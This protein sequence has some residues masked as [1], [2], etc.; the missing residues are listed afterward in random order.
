[1]KGVALVTGSSTGIGFETSIALARNGIY[2]F[3]TMRD[4]QKRD[5]IER[6]AD[7]ESLPLRVIEMDVNDEDSVERT[8]MK[9]IDKEKRID[10]LVNNAG[11]GL[12]GALEDI[13][14]EINSHIPGVLTTMELFIEVLPNVNAV[15]KKEMNGLTNVK[16]QK[17]EKTPLNTMHSKYWGKNHGTNNRLKTRMY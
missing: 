3:A 9:I 12:F 1:M 11:Y 14:L 8:I 5:I 2:T 13:S 17:G 7:K 16:K 6:L 10:I 4:L 15:S